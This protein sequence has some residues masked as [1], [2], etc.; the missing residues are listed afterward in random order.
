MGN[1]NGDFDTGLADGDYCD[2]ISECQQTITVSGGRAHIKPHSG[3]EPVVAICVGC[4]KS[5]TTTTQNPASTSTKTTT[6]KRTTQEETTSSTV[7][8]TEPGFCCDS[9][10]LSS[11]GG[12]AQYYPEL[13]GSYSRLGE[14]NERPVYKH[15]T[16][17]T[18]MHLHYTT[19]P[20]YKVES[21]SA[22]L[23]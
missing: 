10:E 4:G 23:C 5:P 3:D 13:L 7:A 8:S 16:F 11:D 17:L 18:T 19:D 9:L 2:I 20:H 21:Q 12:V 1:V 22:R 14:E 15:Q 6:T